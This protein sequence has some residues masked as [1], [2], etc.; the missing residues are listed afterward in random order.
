MRH[1]RP[2]KPRRSGRVVGCAGEWIAAQ[3]L[4]RRGLRVVARNVRR[5]RDEIDIVLLEGSTLVFVEVKSRTRPR[6][7]AL[8][9]S[10][11]PLEAIDARKRRALERA[12]RSYL[13]A[14]G[15]DV[16]AWRLDG[17]AVDFARFGPLLIPVRIRW[18][19]AIAEIE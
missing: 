18:E 6:S 19:Q 7:R 9:D 10:L 3:Y 5:G 2:R 1:L 14:L 15:W 17:V 4:R 12:A 13:C 8:A 16:P 11:D